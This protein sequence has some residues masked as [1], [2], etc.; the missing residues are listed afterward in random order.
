MS[1]AG[2]IVGVHRQRQFDVDEQ[3]I[4]SGEGG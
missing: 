1:D 4:L 3:R 2:D